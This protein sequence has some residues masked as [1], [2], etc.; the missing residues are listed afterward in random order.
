MMERRAISVPKITIWAN[1]RV[2]EPI[3]PILTRIPSDAPGYLPGCVGYMA[4]SHDR[5]ITLPVEW[6]PKKDDYS[7]KIAIMAAVIN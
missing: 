1:S 7:L 4:A 6:S 3:G 5:R 2:Y